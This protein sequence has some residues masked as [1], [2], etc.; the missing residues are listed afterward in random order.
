MTKGIIIDLPYPE[1]DEIEED[2]Y[3][4]RIIFPAYSWLH[5]ELGAILQYIYHSFYFENQNDKETA[6]ILTGIAVAETLHFNLLGKALVK[7][8]VDPTCSVSFGAKGGHFNTSG[9]SY[10]KTKQ[11]MIM[12]D[13]CAEVGAIKLYDEMLDKLKNDKVGAIIKRIKL[14]E[15]LHIKVLKERIE[16]GFDNE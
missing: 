4:A 9:I 14:D 7:L 1:V 6:K 5:S 12:D 11:K 3:S 16:Q 2:I 8:G 10:S 13:I 15:E